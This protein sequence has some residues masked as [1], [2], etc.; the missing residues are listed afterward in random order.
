MF[1]H[2]EPIRALAQEWKQ[3]SVR[4]RSRFGEHHATKT[5]QTLADEL[6]EC[7]EAAQG[8]LLNLKEAAGVSGYSDDHLGRL[9]RSGDIVNSGR[10]NAPKIALRDLPMKPGHLHPTPVLREVT[11]ASAKRIARSIVSPKEG[12][13]G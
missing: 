6:L 7:I 13:D 1:V 2:S 9:V 8:R 3:E 12:H 5:M 10:P 11:P 4:L